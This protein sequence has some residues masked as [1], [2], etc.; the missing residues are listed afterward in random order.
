MNRDKLYRTVYAD[1]GTAISKYYPDWVDEDYGD[2][3]EEIRLEDASMQ[4]LIEDLEMQAESGNWHS[5]IN[6]YSSIAG[7]VERV[8]GKLTA[9]KVIREIY[10]AGGLLP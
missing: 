2:E 7:I 4:E 5:F 8:A 10:A 6:M 3:V 9:T 1:G